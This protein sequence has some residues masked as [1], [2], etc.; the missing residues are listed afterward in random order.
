M[1]KVTLTFLFLMVIYT[2]ISVTY[3]YD[4]TTQTQDD[5]TSNLIW[6][7]K[8]ANGYYYVESNRF[9]IDFEQIDIE[10]NT[11]L[12][13][14][15]NG[16]VTTP[17]WENFIIPTVGI[18]SS[19][20]DVY[21]TNISTNSI[22]SSSINYE[23]PGATELLYGSMNTSAQQDMYLSIILMLNMDSKPIDFYYTLDNRLNVSED[24]SMFNINVVRNIIRDIT[25]EDLPLT[26]GNPYQEGTTGV[27]S[28]WEYQSESHTFVASII[29]GDIYDITIDNIEFSD[30]SFLDRVESIDYYT[31]DDERYLQLNFDG[32]D[33]VLLDYSGQFAQAWSG[34]SVWNITT[35]ELMVIQKARVLTYI[36]MDKQSRDA[37]AYM[38]MPTV[39]ID[40]LLSVE[41]VFD[42]RYQ[43]IF[44]VYG[45]TYTGGARLTRDE[46]WFGDNYDEDG[47][48][49]RSVPQFAYNMLTLSAVA[50]TT[51][52]IASTTGFGAIVGIPL[53][54]AGGIMLAAADVSILNYMVNGAVDEI[55]AVSPTVELRETIN[56]H[57]SILEGEPIDI[58]DTGQLYRLYLGKFSKPLTIDAEIMNDTYKYTEITWITN[59]EVYTLTE[60]Y[61][62]QDSILDSDWVTRLEEH[63]LTLPVFNGFP[64]WILAVISLIFAFVAIFKIHVIEHLERLIPLGIVYVALLWMLGYIP[65]LY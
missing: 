41:V 33:N 10:L 44:G 60:P 2:T 55:L 23:A 61:M 42:Y 58:G 6:T 28:G 17:D 36:N 39:L 52:A 29:Y 59:G 13:G 22:A 49:A 5:I 46:Q 15:F 35:N 34:F 9:L 47:L 45:S 48:L 57:F 3:A 65:G 11:F 38:Y 21:T 56:D 18:Y 32:N 7:E 30:S 53:L 31:I 25:V 63:E 40:D 24:A 4:Q 43:N 12:S 16:S 37:Y 64:S 50:L 20:I 51:G 1:K 14:S 19:R 27:V 62:D 54:A 26:L 8:E